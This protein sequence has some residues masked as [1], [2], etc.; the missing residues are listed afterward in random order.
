[1]ARVLVVMNTPHT[2]P[3][4][5]Y[6][7]R[8][9]AVIAAL[10]ATGHTVQTI[11]IKPLTASGAFSWR[12]RI[13]VLLRLLRTPSLSLLKWYSPK[14]CDAI[15][16]TIKVWEP[17]VVILES[18]YLAPYRALFKCPVIFDL[19]NIESQLIGNYANDRTGI[20]GKVAQIESRLLERLEAA[21]PHHA[22]GIATV[23]ETDRQTLN[24]LGQSAKV[25]VL[26]APNGVNDEAFAVA[27]DL[28]NSEAPTAVFIGHLG[29][30]PNI[31]GAK[32]LANS[33]W[34]LVHAQIP[35]ARLQLIGRDP[36]HT[37]RELAN[38]QLG[39]TVHG[40]VAS[41]FPYLSQAAVATA[42]L[43]T[44]GGTRLKILEALGTATPVVA[45]SLGALGLEGL[46][47]DQVLTICDEPADFANALVQYL[48][49]AAKSAPAREAAEAFRWS[50]TLTGLV[51]LVNDAVK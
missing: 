46:A 14:A 51:N 7:Q 6:S 9:S 39:I 36:D 13:S 20:V 23:S 3:T 12:S 19:H 30:R 33:V 16:K 15:H 25:K 44:A 28:A 40:N 11:S 50:N 18:S 37:V 21:I 41:V 43:W 48:S 47:G 17:E 31:D 22:D 45:T 5:G 8:V 34:P 4:S 10:E 2:P 42:P 24:Q 1:M 26:A 38:S 35:N 49:N 32:W 27:D 29:W